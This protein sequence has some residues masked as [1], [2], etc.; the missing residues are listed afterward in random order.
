MYFETWVTFRLD[1]ETVT[2]K[3]ESL[4]LFVKSF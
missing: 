4:K 1:Y 2:L 3:L